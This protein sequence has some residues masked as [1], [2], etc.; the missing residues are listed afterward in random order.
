[1]PCR[2]STRLIGI[3]TLERGECNYN[4]ATLEIEYALAARDN[5]VVL[6][7]APGKDTDKYG[8]LLRYVDSAQDGTDFNLHMVSTGLAIARYDSR[9]G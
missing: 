4:A 1:M 9:D 5:S 8:R 2:R 3:D 6:T 7:P